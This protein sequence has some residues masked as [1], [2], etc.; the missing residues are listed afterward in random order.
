MKT[1]REQP[2]W[3]G[4]YNCLCRTSQLSCQMN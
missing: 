1:L 2:A 3:M 4:I